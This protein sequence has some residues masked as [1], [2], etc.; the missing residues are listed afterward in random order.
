MM[1]KSVPPPT[2]STRSG[3]MRAFHA[4]PATPSLLP[5]T[6]SEVR[7]ATVPAT[8]VPWKELPPGARSPGSPGFASQPSPSLEMPVLEMKS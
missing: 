1:S 6:C 5:A 4:T 8:W 7:A 2:P 3:R